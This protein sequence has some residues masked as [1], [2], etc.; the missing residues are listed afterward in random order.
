MENVTN[1]STAAQQ[2]VAPKKPSLVIYYFGN[3]KGKTTAALGLALRA[4]AYKKRVLFAQFVKGDWKTGE[5][6]ALSKIDYLD[7]KK[8][9]L[10]FVYKTDSDAR[11]NAHKAA[12]KTG[13]NFICD[14]FGNY[15]IIVMDEISNAIELGLVKAMDVTNMIHA[16]KDGRTLVLTGS[17]RISQLVS[18]ADLVT[19]MKKI[20][21]PFDKGVMAIESIDW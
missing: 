3:G 11:M 17:A 18:C 1:A 4:S 15:D 21:H 6:Q 14:N 9:G 19:Q 7:H 13:L 20:S 12:A 16:I 2:Q 8:F 10:G 5:D